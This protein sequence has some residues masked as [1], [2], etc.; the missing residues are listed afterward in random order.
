MLSVNIPVYN[1]EVEKLVSQLLEQG[2]K[3]GVP[4]EVRVYDDGSNKT[5]KEKN[6]VL[7]HR[8]NVIY[9]ELKNNLGRAAIRNKMGQESVYDYLLF[10]DADSE[11]VSNH[12][13][14]DFLEM[15]HSGKVLCGGTTYNENKPEDSR[16]LLRWT[17]GTAREAI[18]AEKRN[19]KKGFIITSNNFLIE[20]KLFQKIH[21]REDL[22]NY[23]HE[24]TLLG[25]DLHS[26]GIEIL[27]IDNPVEHTGLEKS[28][29]FLSKTREALKNLHFID[30]HLIP[31]RTEFRGQVHFLHRY[32]SLTKWVPSFILKAFYRLF[33]LWMEKKLSG[34][35]PSMLLFDLYKVGYYSTLRKQ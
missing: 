35:N 4:F 17:Y 31:G 7:S 24:D 10:I 3:L 6:R 28:E 15:T 14:K 25:F 23:G 33:R 1:I 18:S 26:A 32:Y 9:S 5:I 11:L 34:K 30:Q 27:H 13:L 2:E 22:K 16:Q 8:P 21:F 12:Y 20:K 19:G 29:V